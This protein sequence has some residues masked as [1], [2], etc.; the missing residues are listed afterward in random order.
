V[1]HKNRSKLGLWVAGY[2]VMTDSIPTARRTANAGLMATAL[3]VIG[4]TAVEPAL[5][6]EAQQAP[7]QQTTLEGLKQRLDEVE[8]RTG[9]WRTRDSVFHFAGFADAGYADRSGGDDAFDLASFNPIFHYQYQ[10]RVL[11]EAEFETVIDADGETTLDME[12]SSVDVVLNDYAVL[13]A[14]K[15]LSPIGNFQ[16][17]IHPSWINK[18]P[19]EPVGFGHDG[20]APLTDLGVQLRGGFTFARDRLWTY[21]VYVANGPELEAEEG[22]LVAVEADGFARDADRSK[23][24]GG[25]VSLI[26]ITGLEIGL[27]GARGKAAVTR[28]DDQDIEDDP[29]RNY[30]ALAVDAGFEPPVV[31]GGDLL[32][33]REGSAVVHR[34]AAGLDLPA[35][36]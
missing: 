34:P 21:A 19:S 25:R 15:F 23:V 1:N 26:P 18:L 32:G 12:Y 11:L 31:R 30:Q 35:P 29:R 36:G 6:E 9:E 27:S 2:A 4:T 16:Q 20:A 17:N 24:F 5:A 28:S 10:D 8:K 13:I 3:A 7:P 33:E 14:G 22:R